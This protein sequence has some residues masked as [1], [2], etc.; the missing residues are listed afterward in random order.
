ME[1]S[2]CVLLPG[3]RVGSV[4]GVVSAA[5]VAEQERPLLRKERA[6]GCLL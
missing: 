2:G 1:K 4:A 5:G 3:T 6:A